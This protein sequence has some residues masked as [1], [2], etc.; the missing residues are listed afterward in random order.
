MKSSRR[1]F[2]ASGLV[3]PAAGL[4]LPRPGRTPASQ[5]AA[6]VATDKLTYRTLGK[7]GL[8]VTSVG[9]GCMITSDASVIA[10]AADAGIN[11]FDTA[12][13]YQSGNNERMVGAALKGKRQQI[14][15]STKTGA[16][17][18]A[19]ALAHLDTSLKELGTDHVDIW[20][21]HG[22][23][24]AAQLTDDLLEAQQIAKQ[25]GKIRF[26]GV[27]MHSGHSEVIP[28]AIQ[29]GKID[30]I[31]ISYNFAMGSTLDELV[32][33]AKAAGVGVVAMKVMAGGFRRLKEG[34]PNGAILKREGAMAAALR[35]V[36][37]NPDIGTTIPSMTDADQFE[38]N[39]KCMP[40][41][42][43]PEDDKTLAAH[44]ERISPV[45]CR[46]CSLCA[47]TC[48]KGLPV[49]DLLRIVTYADG[50]GQFALGRERYRELPG[51]V[52][53]VRCGDCSSC[54]VQCPHGVH[55][56]KRISRAQ[57]LFG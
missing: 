3:L 23:Q 38:D 15:L 33:K 9:F 12:R 56:A 52:T 36:L 5:S 25:A 14:Y 44:L 10:R 8:K 48:R 6:P 29:S 55:V 24:T 22:K 18:K 30:V 50:Y 19:G 47:G 34:D 13:V 41:K 40:A 27:S 35:W 16:Q 31:L 42:F 17:D 26:A 20:Y 53:S 28:A 39:F 21:L 32:A 7:T 46:M 37:K 1:S 2:L 11:Y 49:S 51:D 43:S 57:E 54:T 45:Y 4:A